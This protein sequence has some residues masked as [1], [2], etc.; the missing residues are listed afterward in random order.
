MK[1]F[2]ILFG[3]SFPLF[4]MADSGLTDM[5]Y[6]WRLITLQSHNS[7]LVL[8]SSMLLG[9]ASGLVGSFLLL[10]KRS[11]MSDTLSHACLPGICLMF[12]VL[13]RM[14]ME[15]K[16]LPM[17]LLGAVITGVLGVVMVTLIQSTTR[18]SDD[19]AMGIVLSVFF[20]FGVVLLTMV[21]KVPGAS[22]AGLE[23][24][25]NGKAASMVQQDFMLLLSMAGVVVVMSLLMTKELT[26]LCF[27]EAYAASLGWPVWLLDLLM[28]MLVTGVTVAGL[29]TVGLILMIAFMITPAAA[30]RFW[31]H[32][33]RHMLWISALIGAFS[34]LIGGGISA[35]FENMPT[36][37]LMVLVAS[38]I[39]AVS[40][41]FGPARGVLKK[42]RIRRRLRRKVSRQHLLRAV[43]ELLESKKDSV[44]GWVPNEPVSVQALLDKRSWT[45][46]SLRKKLDQ[47]KKED[48][49]EYVKGNEIR[50]SESGYGEAARYTRNHRLWEMYLI[51]YAEV[52]AQH[53]DRDA[54]HVEHVLGAELVQQL[55]KALA[56]QGRLAVLPESPHHLTGAGI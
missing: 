40:M 51:H 9:I 55:E 50:L 5:E 33:V 47:A 8:L 23:T 38:T 18:L 52:A 2:G 22:A 12:L 16:S 6:F 56:K 35:L 36:G 15:G 26:L 46:A 53:V 54:D 45:A 24:F 14:G 20:G 11:L 43:F 27:D 29:Q 44:T 42:I 25:I 30:A 1:A 48:H 10:R 32:D 4:A 3:V 28:L 31:T 37:A 17:L 39:F 7:R 49:L 13:T 21:Q 19:A 41:I 34:G